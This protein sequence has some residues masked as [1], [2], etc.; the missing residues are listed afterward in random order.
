[1][2]EGPTSTSSQYNNKFYP[3]LRRITKTKP[4]AKIV[5]DCSLFTQKAPS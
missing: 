5:Y 2:T 1:M 3:E 4:F